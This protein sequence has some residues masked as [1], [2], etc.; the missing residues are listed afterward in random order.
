MSKAA[1]PR[2]GYADGPFGQIHYQTCGEGAPLVLL[3]QA[4]MTSAQ[5]DHV[6]APLAAHGFRVIGIDM[7]GFGG[8]DATSFV[9]TCQDYAKVV[10]SILE[11]LG[12]DRA[13]ILGHHTGALVATEAALQFPDRISALIANG[14]LLVSGEDYARFM[15]GIHEWER[16]YKAQPYAGH[17]VELFGIREKLAAG[18]IS[19]E[20]LSDYVVQAL[21]GEGAFWHGHYAAYVYRQQD[22]LPLIKQPVLILTNT[23]DSIYSHAVAARELCPHFAYTELAGGGV[24]IVDQQPEAWADAVAAFLNGL[25]R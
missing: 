22:V 15:A 10:P 1:R 3:H 13:A 21:S 25:E 23:G 5:F 8:S 12:I 9:P 17:M 16:N 18:T 24:D 19:A 7:P 20:R 2:R 11:H 6:Y 4:L 14:P